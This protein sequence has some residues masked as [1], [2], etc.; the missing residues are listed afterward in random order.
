MRRALALASLPLIAMIPT[1]LNA[2]SAADAVPDARQQMPARLVYPATA[3]ENVTDTQFGVQV[4]D[5]YRWLENDVR[6]DPKV[7]QW[8]DSENAVTNAYLAT[9][10]GRDVLKAR[11]AKLLDFER[12]D[13]PRKAGSRYFYTRNDGLQN[14][15]VLYVQDGLSAERRVLINPNDWAKD[16]ATALAEWKPSGDGQ[17]LVYAI[18]D[19]GSDWRTVRVLDVASGKVLDDEV[20]WVKYSNLDWAKDGSGFYYSRFDA[21]AE[22]QAFQSLSTN[23]QVWFHKVGTPQSADTLIYR[24]PERPALGHSAEVTDDGRY[25][26]VTS[27]QGTDARYEVNVIDLQAKS[28]KPLTLIAGLENSWQ[29]IGNKG[30]L[31]YFVTDKDAPRQ[32]VVTL[33]I[34][35]L[36]AAPVELIAQSD[37]TLTGAGMVGDKIV[38]TYLRDARSEA[39]MITLDGKPAGDVTLPGIGTAYGFGGKAGDSETFYSFSSFAAAPT[40][41]RLDTATGAVS[42]FAQPKVAFDPAQYETVQQFYTSKDGTKVPLFIVRK[43][44]AAPASGAPTLLY[45]YGGFQISVTPSFS[46]TRLAWLEQGGVLAIANLRGGGEYGKEWHDGGRLQNKQNVFDDFIAAGEYLIAQGITGKGQ[47]AVEGRSNGGL[48]IGAV[49]NQR[50]DLFAAALPA[51]GVMDMLRF[52][53]WTAGRYWVDDYGYPA[54]EA[55]FRKLYSYSPYH[56]VKAGV[57]Y[58]AILVT[59]ADTDDRVVPGHS[60]K[61]TAALQAANIGAKPH[62]IRIETRAGHGS[63]KPTDKIIE[64]ASDMYAFI[65]KWTGLP[66]AEPK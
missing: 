4:A 59:T 22:G 52:D 39:K 37:A 1:M 7:K 44:G 9:L 23:Q 56:N 24:T 20:K 31:F 62:L 42:T 41:Y 13:V 16:G 29:L 65:A 2:K 49:V 58:P 60:F 11:M 8:V 46:A 50:P 43:K 48:L 32:R 28:A 19:G 10:P 25:L 34:A 57:D 26:V 66:I 36:K 51:V 21:P 35:K 53:R 40:V 15:S 47:L 12:F 45:G 18:Q 3:R 63:G 38:L 33:D 27:T 64:E 17:K 54:K 6:V 5:P 55:D 14:Q 61:Y 30:T